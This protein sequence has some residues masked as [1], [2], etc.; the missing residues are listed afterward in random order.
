[1]GTVRYLE[2][3]YAQC[4]PLWPPRPPEWWMVHAVITYQFGYAVFAMAPG[5][6]LGQSREMCYGVD[7]GVLP[8]ARGQGY[9]LK[10]HRHRLEYAKCAGA[11]AFIGA[12]QPDNLPMRRIFEKCGAKPGELVKNVYPDGSDGLVYTGPV[13]V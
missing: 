7:I 12:T 11:L 9:G 10:L 1:M 6:H 2:Q 13:E 5:I 4:H 8:D 3:M